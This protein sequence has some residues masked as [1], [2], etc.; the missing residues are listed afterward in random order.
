MNLRIS[1]EAECKLPQHIINL[2]RYIWEI[3]FT[4]QEV[5]FCLDKSDDS[6]QSISVFLDENKIKTMAITSSDPI[7]IKVLFR[8]INEFVIDVL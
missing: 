3:E 6:T 4:N 8:N 1:E 5:M 7:N 2:L